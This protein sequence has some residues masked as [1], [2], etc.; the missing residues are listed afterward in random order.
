MATMAVYSMT[1]YAGVGAEGAQGE[2][3][4]LLI[5]AR[6]VNGRFLD[7]ALRLGDISL[8]AAALS[9]RLEMRFFSH[10]GDVSRQ[11]FSS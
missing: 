4:G 2:A 7:L 8:A 10:V 1:G 11:T 6:S 3:E 9:D 5:E